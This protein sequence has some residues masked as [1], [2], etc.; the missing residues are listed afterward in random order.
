MTIYLTN[1]GTFKGL[2]EVY[3]IVS[4]IIPVGEAKL[5]KVHVIAGKVTLPWPLSTPTCSCRG[6]QDCQAL[7]TF[8]PRPFL[9]VASN[10]HS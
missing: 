5:A 3:K 4:S 9:R 7:I 1:E 10:E 6:C 8:L 2:H